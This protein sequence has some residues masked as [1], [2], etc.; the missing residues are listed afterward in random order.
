MRWTCSSC[1]APASAHRTCG[2][3]AA[4]D[5]GA[6]RASARPGRLD[7][8]G[9]AAAALFAASGT[10]CRLRPRLQRIDHARCVR[11]AQPDVHLGSSC[12]GELRVEAG[13]SGSVQERV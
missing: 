3:H 10:A 5:D 7:R 6:A 8:L 4:F 13:R 11:I 1:I 12:G 9:A 2:R